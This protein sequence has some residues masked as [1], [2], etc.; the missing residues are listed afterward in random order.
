M[1][2]GELA[3][4]PPPRRALKFGEGIHHCLEPVWPRKFSTWIA[5]A[6]ATSGKLF[7]YS[8]TVAPPARVREQAGYSDPCASKAPSSAHA[9]CATLNSWTFR[10]VD[11]AHC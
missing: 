11:L 5:R 2:G 9:F 1:T 6:A 7:T 10:P 3:M 8:S 4:R